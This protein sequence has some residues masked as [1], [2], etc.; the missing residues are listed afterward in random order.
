[1][2]IFMHYK[3]KKLYYFFFILHKIGTF[4]YALVIND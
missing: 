2:T 3:C 1:M 4:G